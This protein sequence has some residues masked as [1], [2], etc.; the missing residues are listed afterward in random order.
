MTTAL[1]GW[2]PTK[3]EAY[4]KIIENRISE[5][6]AS[7]PGRDRNRLL[8]RIRHAVRFAPNTAVTETLVRKLWRESRR[9]FRPYNDSTDEIIY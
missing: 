3:K 4:E 6:P 9:N 7:S 8:R 5:H 2:S 1:L